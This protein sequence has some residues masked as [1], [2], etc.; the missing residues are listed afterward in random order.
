[1]RRTCIPAATLLITATALA[2][3]GAPV[4]RGGH[5]PFEVSRA[6]VGTIDWQRV[7]KLPTAISIG[8]C[9]EG[10]GRLY[11]L[12]SDRTIWVNR[13]GG[14]DNGWSLVTKVSN[15]RE[16]FC[17]DNA[18]YVFTDDRTIDRN[19]GTDQDPRFV[20][21]GRPAKA[22]H[23]TG[24]TAIALFVPYTVLYALHDDNT[25]WKSPSGADGTWSYV[26][27][28]DHAARI[29]A[30]GSELEAR[31]FALNDDNSFWLN[32]G[33]GC[34]AYWHLIAPK[35]S[36][37]E[38][39]A[40]SAFMLYGLYADKTLWRARL[41][42]TEKYTSLRSD[43]LPQHCDGHTLVLN[44]C[45]DLDQGCCPSHDCKDGYA[46]N[47]RDRCESC[48]ATG[49][50]AC[51]G[52]V[53]S[54]HDNQPGANGRCE[55]CGS[56]HERACGGTRCNDEH[57]KPDDNGQCEWDHWCGYEGGPCCNDDLQLGDGDC[58]SGMTCVYR[59]FESDVCRRRTS[60]GGGGG[61]GGGGLCTGGQNPKDF[62]VT[63]SCSP[64][65]P[66]TDR[67]T[68]CTEEAADAI[69]ADRHYPC[70]VDPIPCAN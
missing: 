1:M 13:S 4:D 14:R 21:V 61:G 67:A 34:D 62:C 22:K 27:R 3:C 26:G 25:L 50:L 24:T 9:S 6:D 64:G 35:I 7:G 58:D 10:D 42:D 12:N 57:F 45:G 38:I 53:C 11:A 15:A 17:A 16:V 69:L 32:A 33:D 19:V 43:G 18:L 68:A 56:K 30:G 31:P 46:C 54:D 36:A 55:H 59:V 48:G 60:S 5:A 2:G 49:E 70:P 63:V 8:A 65:Y 28:P 40:A 37:Q 44:A 41:R 66:T 29:A 51:A 20:H 52:G 47:D 39:T 23:V